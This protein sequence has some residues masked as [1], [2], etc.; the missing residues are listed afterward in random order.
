MERAIGP[1]VFSE[2]GLRFRRTDAGKL[3]DQYGRVFDTD[4]DGKPVKCIG[5]GYNNAN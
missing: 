2:N 4:K 3:I 1:I 5:V